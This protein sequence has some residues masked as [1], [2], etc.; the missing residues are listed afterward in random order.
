M[1]ENGE[2]HALSVSPLRALLGGLAPTVEEPAV[3][4]LPYTSVFSTSCSRRTGVRA[5]TAGLRGIVPIAAARSH[6]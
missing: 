5:S 3:G 1:V 2:D 4:R 6:T